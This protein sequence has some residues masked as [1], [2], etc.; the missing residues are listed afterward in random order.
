MMFWEKRYRERGFEWGAD[1]SLV[2]RIVA[3][4]LSGNKHARV[5]DIGCGYG[6]DCIYLARKGFDVVGVD[7][8]C[9]A[10][11]LGEEWKKREGISNIQFVCADI[12]AEAIEY[13]FASESFD[14]VALYNVMQLF[15]DNQRRNLAAAFKQILKP[16]GLLIQA[17]FS[18][19][20][21]GYGCGE[22]VEKNSYLTSAGRFRH[23]FCKEEIEELFAGFDFLRLEQ[24]VIPEQQVGKPPHVHQ[25]WL[26]VL[27]TPK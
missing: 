23:F 19:K 25:E 24:V 5:L 3:D 16:G 15:D 11:A 22:L 27:K 13:M 7:I 26:I 21:K 8:S 1:P 9:V 12:K 20:E 6:R 10:L 17:V 18:E 4:F 2:G 14:A